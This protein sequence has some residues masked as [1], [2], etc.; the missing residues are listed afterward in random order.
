MWLSVFPILSYMGPGFSSIWATINLAPSSWSFWSASGIESSG[1]TRFSEY[2]FRILS[3]S[4][5]PEL[6]GGPWIADFR[7]WTKPELSIRF[8]VFREFFGGF[9][10]LDDFVFG[11]SVSNTPQSPPLIFTSGNYT[12]IQ[13]T[14]MRGNF[15]PWTLL[16]WAVCC[17]ISIQTMWWYSW[18]FL[19]SNFYTSN[20]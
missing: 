1:R 18:E 3:Q 5:L 2:S 13:L 16:A 14:S 8:S 10:V 15:G 12:K 7:C 6:T 4:D 9:A 20:F 17:A 19:L 11:F